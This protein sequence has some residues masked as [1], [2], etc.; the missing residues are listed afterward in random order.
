MNSVP[1]ETALPTLPGLPAHSQQKGSPT[2]AAFCQRAE[3]Q[4]Q[5]TCAAFKKGEVDAIC[6]DGSRGDVW[7][8]RENRSAC[9][10][11]GVTCMRHG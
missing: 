3:A 9:G 8:H 6:T 1:E 2:R 11:T 7:C 4:S 10:A 5:W